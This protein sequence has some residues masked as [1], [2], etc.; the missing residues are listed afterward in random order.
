MAAVVF[1]CVSAFVFG[2][3]STAIRFALRK[4]PEPEIAALAS[5]LVALVVTLAI[6]AASVPTP[7]ELAPSR[8][9][10]FLLAGLIAPGLSQ[11]F[12][13]QAV[14]DV[15]SSRTSVLVGAAPLVSV[16]IALLA[17]GEPLRWVLIVG[18]LLIVA[19][20]LALGGERVRPAEFRSV[21]VL[22]ALASAAMFATRDNFLRWLAVDARAPALV[23]AAVAMAGGTVTLLGYLLARRRLDGAA[24]RRALKPFLLPGVLFGG[25]Y[26]LLF[27]AYYRGKV[28]VVSPLVAT[29]SLWGVLFAVALL[30]RSEQVGRHVALGAL[31]VVAGG[32]LI[33][34][35][36]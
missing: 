2:G 23:A 9:W 5:S 12:F 21:G 26:S 33:G 4:V 6:A 16:T 36:R 17:L 3:L 35:A 11:L 29:E 31:L 22:L 14:R 34:I 30:R 32:A 25:S 28:S 1:A 24:L 19:G 7:D 27:E 13:V 18:A 8:L 15:G 20:G 10:P